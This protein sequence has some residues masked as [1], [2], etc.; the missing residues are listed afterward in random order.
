MKM[1]AAERGAEARHSQIVAL[2]SELDECRGALAA[3][4]ARGRALTR[5]LSHGPAAAGMEA[6]SWLT[7]S[8]S[9]FERVRPI[10]PC[11]P[12]PMRCASRVKSSK[13]LQQS[14][15]TALAD[16]PAL[17]TAWSKIRRKWAEHADPAAVG[18]SAFY[19]N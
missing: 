13:E 6:Y 12:L 15:S 7:R 19:P 4:N 9:V 18:L 8:R 10:V 3:A 2:Q 14:S 17:K 16:A 1:A 5:A 11:R